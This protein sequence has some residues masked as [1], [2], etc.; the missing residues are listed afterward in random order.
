MFL[1]DTSK[2]FVEMRVNAQTFRNLDEEQFAEFFVNSHPGEIF[3]HVYTGTENRHK[4]TQIS[5]IMPQLSAYSNHEIKMRF[6]EGGCMSAQ[7]NIEP[8]NAKLTDS[9]STN[10]VTFQSK[11][12]KDDDNGDGFVSTSALDINFT[13]ETHVSMERDFQANVQSD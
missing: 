13:Y 11:H 3:S 10:F 2:K 5:F 6:E 1:N 4:I 8:L 7:A 9:K 12:F